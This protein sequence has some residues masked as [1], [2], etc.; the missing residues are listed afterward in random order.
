MK[1]QGKQK[2][3]KPLNTELKGLNFHLQEIG[4]GWRFSTICLPETLPSLLVIPWPVSIYVLRL[5]QLCVF[6]C[7]YLN[8]LWFLNGVLHVTV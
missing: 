3:I 6:R 2:L 4:P 7:A 1:E 8:S 5:E